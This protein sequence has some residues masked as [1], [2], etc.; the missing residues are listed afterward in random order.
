[1]PTVLDQLAITTPDRLY[2]AIPKTT[3]VT[4]GFRD[5]SVADMA[6]CVNFMAKWIENLHGRSQNFETI[7]YIGIPDLRGPV[8]FQAAVKCGY[9]VHDPKLA[10]IPIFNLLSDVVTTTFTPQSSF[11]KRIFDGTNRIDQITACR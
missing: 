9:K 1:M 8:I 4:E 7:S 3:D 11:D 10:R 6:R 2:G 5:I